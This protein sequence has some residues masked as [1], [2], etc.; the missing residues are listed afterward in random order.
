MFPP[1]VEVVD[2]C[3][4]GYGAHAHAIIKD[5]KIDSIYI[6]SEGENYPVE[7]APPLFIDNVII[8]NPGTGYDDDTTITDDLGNEYVPT[9]IAG[10]I[11]KVTPINNKEITSIPVFN[12]IGTGDGAQLS[13]VLTD[14]V[15]PQGE[16]KQVID[17]VS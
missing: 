4:Q 17:C 12:I 6:V 8:V 16:V 15:P 5:N 14:D 2:E 3:G 9:I 10:S 11:V 7:E 1:F 13:A